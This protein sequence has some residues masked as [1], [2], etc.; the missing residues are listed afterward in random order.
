MP[1][2][3]PAARTRLGNHTAREAMPHAVTDTGAFDETPQG[4]VRVVRIEDFGP[5]LREP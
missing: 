2:C 4:A 1:L 3:G 5:A